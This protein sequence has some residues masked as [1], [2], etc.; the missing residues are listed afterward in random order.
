MKNLELGKK[1]ITYN[2]RTMTVLDLNFD[3]NSP[4]PVLCKGLTLH[5]EV[6]VYHYNINGKSKLTKDLDICTL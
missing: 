5:G 6:S 3:P 2:G 4:Y 1:Y